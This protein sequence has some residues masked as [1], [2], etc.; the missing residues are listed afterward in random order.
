[1]IQGPEGMSRNYLYEVSVEVQDYNTEEVERKTFRMA[2]DN[3]LSANQ[4][5]DKFME[6][7]GNSFDDDRTDWSTLQFEGA[8]YRK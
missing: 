8:Y 7:H 4:T 6:M 2:Y 5:L 1:M 3:Q